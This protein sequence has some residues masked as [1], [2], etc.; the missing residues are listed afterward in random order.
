[1]STFFCDFIKDDKNT[2][3]QHQGFVQILIMLKQ[4][5]NMKHLYEVLIVMYDPH[6]KILLILEYLMSIVV[7][8]IINKVHS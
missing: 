5:I 6:N 1:M 3:R 8:I 4:L 7:K 2:P